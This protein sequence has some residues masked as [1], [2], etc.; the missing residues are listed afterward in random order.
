MD[1]GH[2]TAGDIAV[3]L[4]HGPVGPD[5][6]L[7]R[8]TVVTMNADGDGRWRGVLSC[9]AAGRY[10]YTVRVVPSHPDLSSFAELG[11][12]TWVEDGATD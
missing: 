10:G 1:L 9:D 4:L 12:V 7:E 11:V 2:L 5:G 3:Q 8:A 6:E